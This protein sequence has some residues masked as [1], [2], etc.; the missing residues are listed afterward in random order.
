[1]LVWYYVHRTCSAAL[2]ADEVATNRRPGQVLEKVHGKI[3]TLSQDLGHAIDTVLLGNAVA[4]SAAPAG[5]LD[6]RS[7]QEGRPGA[8]L[9]LREPPL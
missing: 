8:R 2:L 7:G 4:T 9:S 1:M 6:I 5:M 3:P